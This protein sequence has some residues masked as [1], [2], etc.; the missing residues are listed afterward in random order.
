MVVEGRLVHLQVAR[1]LILE[2]TVL[3]VIEE[4]LLHRMLEDGS[5]LLIVE[6]FRHRISAIVLI[7][8][9]VP[10]ELPSTEV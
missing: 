4:A 10:V 6:Q 2:W 9:V 7:L 8:I 3:D 5:L 1:H